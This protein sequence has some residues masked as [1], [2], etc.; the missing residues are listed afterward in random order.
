MIVLDLTNEVEFLK[1]R[2]HCH[3]QDFNNDENSNYDQQHVECVENEAPKSSHVGSDC[4]FVDVFVAKA[5]KF[6]ESKR[7]QEM[8]ST[9]NFLRKM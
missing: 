2:E 1:K 4:L 9:R 6:G 5:I 7:E 3:P 8:I